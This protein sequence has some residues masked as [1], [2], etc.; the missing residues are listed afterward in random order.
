MVAGG[1]ERKRPTVRYCQ[2]A[3]G[4]SQFIL[5]QPQI[6]GHAHK[7][8]V[9]VLFL[10]YI[11]PWSSFSLGLSALLVPQVLSKSNFGSSTFF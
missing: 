5:G 4:V 9:Y 11:I 3:R 2:L 8:Y 10:V 7:I 1:R 6:L